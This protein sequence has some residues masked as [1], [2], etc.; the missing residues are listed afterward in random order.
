MMSRLHSTCSQMWRYNHI[1]SSKLNNLSDIE[2]SRGLRWKSILFQDPCFN[3]TCLIRGCQINQL[4][5]KSWYILCLTCTNEKGIRWTIYPLLFFEKKGFFH[6]IF[7]QNWCVYCLYTIWK[8]FEK[9]VMEKKLCI[10]LVEIYGFGRWKMN[11][12][13]WFWNRQAM[14]DNDFIIFNSVTPVRNIAILI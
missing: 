14:F 11:F 13:Y 12:A 9:N 6:N 4:Q 3:L 5:A 2:L 10:N 1:L 8:L 7:F